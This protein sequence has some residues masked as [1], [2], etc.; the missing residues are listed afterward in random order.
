MQTSTPPTAVVSSLTALKSTIMK[1]SGL[2]PVMFSTV[3]MV[4][5]GSRPFWPRL[6][7]KRS[8]GC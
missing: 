4:Q 5:P 2:R 1:W 8:F 7:L 3:F 6:V